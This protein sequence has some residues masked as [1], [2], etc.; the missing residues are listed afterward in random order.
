MPFLIVS[1]LYLN[2]CVQGCAVSYEVA[3]Q[4]SAP[5]RSGAALIDLDSASTLIW[6]NLFRSFLIIWHAE[7]TYRATISSGSGSTWWPQP[8]H[9]TMSLTCAAAALPS[10]IGGPGGDFMSLPL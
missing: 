10:V 2:F 5:R 6:I 1:S 9:H 4:Q 8:L 3:R 7:R